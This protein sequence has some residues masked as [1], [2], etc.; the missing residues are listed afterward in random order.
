MFRSKIAMWNRLAVLGLL[1]VI[2]LGLGLTNGTASADPRC[3]AVHGHFTLEPVTGPDCTSPVGI[4]ATGR[5]IGVISG[6]SAFTGSSLVPTVDTPSTSVV[7]LTGDN[8]ITTRTGTLTTKDAIVLKTTGAGD[9]A[10]VDTI[11]GGT[12]AW[13]GATG[14]IRAQGTFTSAGGEGDYI[15]E[16]CLP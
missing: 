13:A 11:V 10:E 6:A 15:G 5:Y 8:V 3:R 16:I 4:C 9:F 2:G 1:A 14:T 7:V 12:G